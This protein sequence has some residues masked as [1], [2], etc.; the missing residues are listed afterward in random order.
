MKKVLKV[1]GIVAPWL[2]VVVLLITPVPSVKVNN[3]VRGQEFYALNTQGKADVCDYKATDLVTEKEE[4][5]LK[6]LEVEEE[7]VVTEQDVLDEVNYE[8]ANY[9]DQT[10]L[11]DGMTVETG[12]TV[13]LN[14]SVKMDSVDLT[15]MDATGEDVEL[16]SG[17]LMDGLEDAIVGHAIGETFDVE[18][19][20]PESFS[21]ELA[22]QQITYTVT[23]N[24]G[25]IT[26]EMDAD[27]VTDE[28]IKNNFSDFSTVAEYKAAMQ[29]EVKEYYRIEFENNKKSAVLKALQDACDVELPDDL[30]KQELEM[31]KQQFERMYCDEGMDLEEYLSTY[32]DMTVE[33]FEDEVKDNVKTSTLNVLLCQ[34]YADKYDIE[35]TDEDVAAYIDELSQ[36][37]SYSSENADEVYGLYESDYMSGEEYVTRMTLC[38]KVVNHFVEDEDCTFKYI[39]AE[40]EEE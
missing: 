38:D 36:G 34:F 27:T 12:M 8:L 28:F 40:I 5:N 11:P 20:V 39:A 13:N 31:Y 2:L 3:F 23:I 7:H 32:Y 29:E 9:T 25:T 1:V 15:G 14:Y 30:V 21:E 16:G 4:P 18:L 10:E 24:S 17:Y 26:T 6:D 33:D 37:T 19:T 35:V 22:G